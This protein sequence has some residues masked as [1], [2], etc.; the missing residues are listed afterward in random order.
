[1]ITPVKDQE[2]PTQEYSHRKVRFICEC[3]NEF[4]TSW[5]SFTTGKTRTCGSC[6]LFRWKKSRVI[7]YGRLKTAAD[8]DEVK[9]LTQRLQ[10]ACDC[11]R[12]TEASLLSVMTGRVRSCGCLASAKKKPVEKA[13][14]RTAAEWMVEIPEL[15]DRDL[16]ESWSGGVNARLWFLCKCGNKYERKFNRFRTG[17][18]TCKRCGI[19]PI[20][21]GDVVNGFIYDGN[22]SEIDCS[23]AGRDWFVCLCGRREHVRVR[24]VAK[25]IQATC[26]RCG[27]M[28]P[29]DLDKKYGSLRLRVQPTFALKKHSDREVEFE[30]DCG[31]TLK[32]AFRSVFNGATRSCGRCR[33]GIQSWYSSVREE[34][35]NATFPISK[36]DPLIGPLKPLDDVI[37]PS[38]PLRLICP[39]CSKAHSTKFRYVRAG[40]GLTCGCKSGQTSLAQHEIAEVIRS[41]GMEAKVE[42]EAD[43]LRYDIFVPFANLLIEYHGLKWHSMSGARQRDRRKYRTA[44]SGGYDFLCIY[45]D[46]W[47]GNRDRVVDLLKNRVGGNR[48]K[49]VRASACEVRMVT[50]EEADALYIRHHYIGPCKSR[51]GYGAFLDGR[52]LACISFKAPTR[53]SSHP[54]ELVRMVSDPE[55]RVH[56]VWRRLVGAFLREHQPSSVVSFSDNR[57]FGGGVYEKIGFKHDGDITSDYCWVKGKKRHHKSGLRKPK[58]ETR[59]ETVIREAEGYRRMWDL[60]KKRWVLTPESFGLKV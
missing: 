37:G 20:A 32:A 10:W 14:E 2:I 56:G 4:E 52:L 3:E 51:T 42:H 38:S 47:K 35:R 33:D 22:A 28:S 55:F 53:Q 13:P 15:L 48:P 19:V 21:R 8:P 24:N 36:D 7:E 18:S 26:G 40:E 54:W 39:L 5:S 30:C 27:E 44:I 1:M 12:T 57:L 11:G 41:F 6:K 25:G 45:E 16:P 58:G 23:S 43:G 31:N 9:K 17:V 46:E 60:G 49:P 59:T 50:L 29:E 34:L